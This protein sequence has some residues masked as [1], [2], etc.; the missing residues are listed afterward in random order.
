MVPILMLSAGSGAWE[1][2]GNTY[3]LVLYITNSA[4]PHFFG[5]LRKLL[6]IITE[7]CYLQAFQCY[8]KN[9]TI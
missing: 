5:S 3:E 2:F 9:Y 7:I 4:F 8:W 1:E 6:T